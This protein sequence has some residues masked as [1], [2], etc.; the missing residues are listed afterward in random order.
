MKNKKRIYVIVTIIIV[1]LLIFL[2]VIGYKGKNDF[3]SWTDNSES[4]KTLKEYVENVT[5]KNSKNFI[6]TK[7]RIA[8]FDMDGTLMGELSPTY[9]DWNLY[10]YRVLDDPNYVGKATP[11]MIETAEYIR[12]IP[13]NGIP[14]WLEEAHIRDN[15][16][17]YEGVT[18]EEFEKI[19]RNFLNQ[20]A[21]GFKNVK[22]SELFYKPMIEVVNYLQKHGF[23]VF[24]VSGTDTQ[25]CRLAVENKLNIPSYHVIGSVYN[26]KLSGQGDNDGLHYNMR[27]E[28][29]IIRDGTY[30]IKNVKSNKVNTIWECIGQQPVLSFGNS[31][32]DISMSKYVTSNNPY[33]SQA[34]FVLADD[35][36]REYGKE[37]KA[38][39]FAE[40]VKA[41][42]WETFSM[43]NDW[44]TIYGEDVIRTF[45]K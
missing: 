15:A 32:G 10:A 7:D 14:E 31:G 36:I 25:V 24:I 29:K 40:T 43:K 4:L 18:I 26:V 9:F 35:E 28:D 23:T 27:Q 3:Q 8:V 13:T 22:Y 37:E 38:Q 11:E 21:V 20:D 19:V 39:N 30:T 1:A 34:F 33:R 44:K 5:N 12:R 45:V 16:K 2:Y 42:G 6:P 41:N 17:A